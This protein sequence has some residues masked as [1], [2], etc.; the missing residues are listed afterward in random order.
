MNI[1]VKVNQTPSAQQ[2][3]LDFEDVIHS[4]GLFE[5]QG[6][7]SRLVGLGGGN[8]LKLSGYGKSPIGATREQYG[9]RRFRKCDV[10][11]ITI[12]LTA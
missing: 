6:S 9:N 8:A 5:I 2:F 11:E 4:V 12:Q 10:S 3:N 1:G 7:A